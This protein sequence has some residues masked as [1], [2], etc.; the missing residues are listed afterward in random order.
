MKRLEIHLHSNYSCNLHCKHC[1]NFSDVHREAEL[2][3]EF[4]ITLINDLC[5]QYETE[6]HLEG[7]EIFLKPRFL[8]LL[9]DLPDEVLKCITITT[10]GTI[11]LKDEAILSA[12]RKIGSLRIS[13]EGHTN[14]QQ[15]AVRG[16]DID[17]VLENA[18]YYMENGVPVWLRVTLNQYNQD[19]FVNCTLPALS[20]KG[21]R[22]IQVYEFQKVGRG[23]ENNKELALNGTI[24]DILADLINYKD[25]L[26]CELKIMLSQ[27]RLCEVKEYEQKLNENP[28]K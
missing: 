1:Y 25:S 26:E 24:S 15:R 9:N 22:R 18:R 3:A 7:G 6:I 2:P 21:F 14:E 12:L 13:V 16:I 19:G 11:C 4:M 8:V 28:R 20:E 27:R 23:S 17:N 5:K 10:N